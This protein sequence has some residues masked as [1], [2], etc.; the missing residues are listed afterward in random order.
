MADPV[1]LPGSPPVD[2]AMP[3]TPQRL[4]NFV[5][6][7]LSLSGLSNLTGIIIGSS[8]PAV[9]DRDKAW[10]KV[11]SGSGRAV[12]VY[13]FLGSWVQIPNVPLSG[14]NEPASPQ[15]GELF[16]NTE[17]KALKAYLDAG[18]TTELWHKGATSDRPTGVPTGYLF[19]DTDI[20]RLLRYTSQGWSTVDGAIGEVRMMDGV[21]TDEATTRNP[22]WSVYM[23]L[24]G[25]FIVGYDG[26]EYSVGEEGGRQTVPWSAAGNAAQ[27][28]SREQGLVNSLSIDGTSFTASSGPSGS[29]KNGEIDIRPPYHAVLFI[30]KDF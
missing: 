23:A 18:W 14:E 2:A 16:Y 28:G 10:I 25:K 29:S 12:G 27:G 15:P 5:A 22:G 7:Y 19:F 20:K 11:D 26:D 24:G 4:I 3:D 13:R 17:H 8:E 6:A 30:R 21:T 9:S 1:L